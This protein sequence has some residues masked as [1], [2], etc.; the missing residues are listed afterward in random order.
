MQR[1]AC[2]QSSTPCSNR[3]SNL[4]Y[5]QVWD[6]NEPAPAS[7]GGPFDLILASH[8][9]YEARDLGASLAHIGNA[10][11]PGGFLLFQELVSPLAA[12]LWGLTAAAWECSGGRTFGRWSDARHWTE[13]CEA[14]GFAAVSMLR[15][16][17]YR[18]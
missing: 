13:L 15:C 3:F 1:F 14:A 4:S 12:C 16:L 7:M 2:Q 18:L 6:I 17:S 8:G 10:L 9:V 5:V 11:A